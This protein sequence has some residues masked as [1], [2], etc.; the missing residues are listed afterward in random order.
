MSKSAVLSIR[1]EI[2]NVGGSFQA[3]WYLQPNG[4]EEPIFLGRLLDI[5][6]TEAVKMAEDMGYHKVY[7]RYSV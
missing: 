6:E 1:S 4:D 7:V 2:Y 3:L 5:T